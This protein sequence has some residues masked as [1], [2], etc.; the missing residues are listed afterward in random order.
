MLQIVIDQIEGAEKGWI[1]DGNYSK[2]RPYILP[3]AD[4]V[5]WLNLP[6][7]A[8]TLRVAKRTIKNVIN[9]TR[10][11]GDNYESLKSALLPSSI[12]WYNAFGGKKSQ[13]R[14]AKALRNS[15]LDATIYEIRSYRQLREFYNNC[16][17]DQNA[18]LT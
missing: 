14:I 10:I 4:T 17:L 7:W 16:G 15:E 3:M 8:T 11:C 13:T 1:I 12:I 5:I 18:Y 6:R 9:K 2:I